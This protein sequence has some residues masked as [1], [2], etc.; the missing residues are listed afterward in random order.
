MLG[1]LGYKAR[2][3]VDHDP[4]T[5]KNLPHVQL[6]FYGWGADYATTYSFLFN[7]LMCAATNP[8]T[9]NDLTNISQF[10]NPAIDAK[11]ERA[12]SIQ[13]S[14]PEVSSRL[15]AEVDREIVDEAPWVPYSTFIKP[16]LLSPRVK[17]YQHHP[18]W[19]T[20]LGQ[21]WVR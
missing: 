1:R 16:E 4:Y 18:Q 14:D 19:G 17:N 2:V 15:W 11:I 9:N 13:A 21:L 6:G 5:I 12:A 7:I 10:C 20:L 8:A 3:R